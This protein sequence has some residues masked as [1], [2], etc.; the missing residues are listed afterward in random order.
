MY[1]HKLTCFQKCWKFK[2]K[3]SNYVLTGSNQKHVY[4]QVKLISSC[5]YPEV[6]LCTQRQKYH[7]S[8]ARR[9]IYSSIEMEQKV[10]YVR[11]GS[12][13]NKKTTEIATNA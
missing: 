10:S 4:Q 6:Q 1:D 13:K 11:Q 9:L 5:I 8:K 3:K 12:A 2:K 7:K